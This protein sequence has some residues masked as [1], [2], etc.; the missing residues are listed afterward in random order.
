MTQLEKLIIRTVKARVRDVL[1]AYV[2]MVGR[3]GVKG[4]ANWVRSGFAQG[5]LLV[6]QLCFAN[7]TEW[8][9]NG[10]Y[11]CQ[12]IA[13]LE[14]QLNTMT[15]LV[16]EGL[17]KLESKCFSALLTYDVFQR[18]QV[19]ALIDAKVTSPSDF[20]WMKHPKHYCNADELYLQPVHGYADNYAGAQG[21][22]PKAYEAALV[23]A[24]DAVLAVEDDAF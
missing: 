10:G 14:T 24:H 23:R 15:E 12:Y 1:A 21:Y 5:I 19:Q 18:D 2:D 20:D 8:A 7:D 22:D 3:D 4:R 13:Q 6:N 11:L 16:R 17:N 9:I